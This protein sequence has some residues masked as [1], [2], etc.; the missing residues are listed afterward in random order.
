[1]TKLKEK[2][3]EEFEEEMQKITDETIEEIDELKNKKEA[4]LREL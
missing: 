1:M 2:L 3:V 4:E